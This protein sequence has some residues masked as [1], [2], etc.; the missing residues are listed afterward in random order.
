[1]K[2]EALFLNGVYESVLEEV[3]QVQGALPEHIMFL[4]PY[5]NEAIAKLRDD[6]PSVED[7]CGCSCR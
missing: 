7:L 4:Q 6:P 5:R 3:L 1:M 2:A